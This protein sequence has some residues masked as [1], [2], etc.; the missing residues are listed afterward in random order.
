MRKVNGDGLVYLLHFER[1]YKHAAHY[2][3]WVQRDLP[4]RLTRH[5]KGNGARLM[6]VVAAAGIGFHLARL[7]P[8]DR[9][10]ERALKNYGGARRLCPMCTAQPW[11]VKYQ[12]LEE[13]PD[14]YDL[15]WPCESA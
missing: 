13:I 12:P 14:E 5:G 8:G 3:G 9:A 15:Y 6:E 11:G 4:Q 7:W 2:L 10:V 1:P